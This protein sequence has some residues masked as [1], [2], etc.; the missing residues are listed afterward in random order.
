M[1]VD[2]Q[3]HKRNRICEIESSSNT[4]IVI[5]SIFSQNNLTPINKYGTHD[6]LHLINSIESL[7]NSIDTLF[8]FGLYGCSS[9]TRCNI[10]A[11]HE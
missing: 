8:L 5:P 2:F 3:S 6:Y 7:K 10:L 4:F 11:I 9:T 1:K